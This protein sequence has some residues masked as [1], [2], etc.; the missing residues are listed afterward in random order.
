MSAGNRLY[1]RWSAIKTALIVLSVLI[2]MPSATSEKKVDGYFKLG[3]GSCQDSR[4]K[5]YSYVQRTSLFP[6]AETCAGECGRWL[7]A[8]IYR[9]FEWSVAK[10]CTCLFDN[11]AVPAVPNSEAEPMYVSQ[12]DDG[13]GVVKGISNT[14]GAWCYAKGAGSMVG[15]RMFYVVSAVASTV[16]YALS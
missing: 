8:E 6:E 14:P 9:G 12:L 10:R 7:G 5:M 4:G 13:F 2:S 15:V 11:D 1:S 16:F 3:K